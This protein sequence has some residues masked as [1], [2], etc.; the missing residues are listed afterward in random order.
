MITSIG[1]F[2]LGMASACLVG[3]A[4]L[5]FFIPGYLMEKGKN[6]A[7]KEDVA[8]ITRQVQSV[9]HEYEVLLEELKGQNQVRAASLDRR[10]QAHQDAFSHWRSLVV[11]A[12]DRQ[13]AIAECDSW[14]EK[15]CL[16][17]EPAVSKAFFEAYRNARLHDEFL[18]IRAE[19]KLITETHDKMLAFPDVLFECVKLHPLTA[20]EREEILEPPAKATT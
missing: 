3:L 12:K 15:N 17:L 19:A 18:Q 4:L 11:G 16:Y 9:R 2:G 13:A 1:I 7:T 6:L 20:S 8:A 14:W 5:K 10:L